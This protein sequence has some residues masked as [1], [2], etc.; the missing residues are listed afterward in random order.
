ML[1]KYW[2]NQ[3]NKKKI[4]NTQ[5]L[6]FKNNVYTLSKHR[7]FVKRY[8]DT[9][10]HC[11]MVTVRWSIFTILNLMKYLANNFDVFNTNI[12]QLFLQ[13]CYT[14]FFLEGSCTEFS[15]T[16]SSRYSDNVVQ[17][18]IFFSP[19]LKSVGLQPL[20]IR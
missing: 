19:T 18:S 9:Y 7:F 6:Q 12:V 15:R 5:I 4:G 13:S 20:F 1:V 3:Y 11:K 14:F 10:F 8:L 2:Y 16:Q 17:K